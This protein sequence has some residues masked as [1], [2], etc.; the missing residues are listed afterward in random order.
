MSTNAS[1]ETIVVA[2]RQASSTTWMWWKEIRQLLPLAVLLLVVACLIIVLNAIV[3]SLLGSRRFAL[4]DEML[5][6][7]FPGLFATGAGPLLVGQERASR[8]L[9]WLALLPISSKRLITTKLL[10]GLS[11]LGVMWIA[12]AVMITF[13][14]GTRGWHFGGPNLYSGSLFSYPVWIAHSVF[15]LVAGFF[16]SWKIR[17]QFYSLVALVPIAFAPLVCTSV[18]A[19]I[20]G[21]RF[22]ADEVDSWALVFTAIG[23]A[24]VFPWMI[25]AAMRTLSPT[26]A[27]RSFTLLDQPRRRHSSSVMATAPRFSTQLAPL[28][29]QSLN[30]SVGT[31]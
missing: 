10:V 8:T 1:L 18:L 5:M 11:G 2:N 31:W 26:A 6:L 28:I 15:V 16:V 25:R 29:W 22:L 7:V 17:S 3:S 24:I 14:S 4:P 12:A 20:Q 30:A 19:A 23:L 13:F 21:R 27:P 9:D